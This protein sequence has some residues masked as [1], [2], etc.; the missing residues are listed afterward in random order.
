MDKIKLAELVNIN[1]QKMIKEMRSQLSKEVELMDTTA[2]ITK[3]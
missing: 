3:N 2:A 1:I